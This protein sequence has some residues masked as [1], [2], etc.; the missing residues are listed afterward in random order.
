MSKTLQS[1][2]RLDSIDR[3]LLH[4]LQQHG[5]LSFAELARRVRL[6][7]PEQPIDL[8]YAASGAWIGLD[9]T[10]TGGRK[11]TYRLTAANAP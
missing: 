3:K 1:E 9:S 8:W 4:H 10:V 2:F 5:R 7:G 6:T 11:L